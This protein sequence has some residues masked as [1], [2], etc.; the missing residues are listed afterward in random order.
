MY[1]ILRQMESHFKREDK[2]KAGG[3]S[4]VR[5]VFIIEEVPMAMGSNPRVKAEVVRMLQELRGFGAGLVL[6]CRN[7]AIGEDILRETNQKIT[8]ML[9]VPRDRAVV[10]TTLGLPEP[11]LIGKLA[12]GLVFARIARNPTVPV[13]ITPI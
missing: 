3:S 2:G 6:V 12:P 1:F 5:H 13:R 10:A 7:P 9:D 4:Q 8:H 11:E